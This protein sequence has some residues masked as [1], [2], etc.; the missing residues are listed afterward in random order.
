[1]KIREINYSTAKECSDILKIAREDDRLR[2]EQ[3]THETFIFCVSIGICFWCLIFGL[4]IG[5]FIAKDKF[6]SDKFINKV[7]K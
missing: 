5:L 6:F 4:F 3:N 1:M 2:F 7:T